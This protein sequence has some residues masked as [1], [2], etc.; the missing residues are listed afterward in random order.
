MDVESRNILFA[1]EGGDIFNVL[2]IDPQIRSE[3]P[4]FKNLLILNINNYEVFHGYINK[5][6]EAWDVI[7]KEEFKKLILIYNT[8]YVNYKSIQYAREQEMMRMADELN[9]ELLHEEFSKLSAPPSVESLAASMSKSSVSSKKPSRRNP[10]K[11][12]KKSPGISS[13]H[14]EFSDLDLGR[15]H[16]TTPYSRFG[17]SSK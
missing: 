16:K 3:V 11:S 7:L 13:I 12:V 15:K 6:T 5:I 10:G 2:T 8:N 4:F 1:M 9:A 17:R 14:K